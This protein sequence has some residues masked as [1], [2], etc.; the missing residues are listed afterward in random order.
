MLAILF[1]QTL[2]QHQTHVLY[3]RACIP[4]VG[5]LHNYTRLGSAYT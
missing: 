2:E 3:Q 1:S 5:T 4:L